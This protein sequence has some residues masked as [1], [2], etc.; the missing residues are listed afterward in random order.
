MN[1]R[2]IR[3][4]IVDDEKAPADLLQALLAK[5]GSV[6]LVA[7]FNNPDIAIATIPTLAPDIVF[8][9][10]NMP[11]KDGFQVLD[12]LMQ[13]E[14]LDCEVVFTTAHEE[15]A[16]K[17]FDYAAF[18]YLL[19]PIDPV[20][21]D[22][23]IQRYSKHHTESLKAKASKL[24][25]ALK[26]LVFRTQKGIIFIDPKELL[27]CEADGNYTDLHFGMG[28]KETVSMNL[29]HIE[30]ILNVHGFFRVSRSCVI[31]LSS[32]KSVE[33]RRCILEK[34]GETVACEIARDKVNQLVML[35][36]L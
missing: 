30:Q 1:T 3:A 23:T 16:L 26:K 4:I 13:H 36:Q 21:L 7:T 35:L 20:R 29:G 10:I 19:K 18:G 17:A 11:G 6:E 8:L 25:M 34:E 14:A 27:Y 24:L 22:E 28:K 5:N 9:D 2:K 15:H 31:N 32:I 33:K 12:A